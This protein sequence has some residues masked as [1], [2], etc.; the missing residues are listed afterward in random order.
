[1]KLLVLLLTGCSLNFNA[2]DVGK[3]P[4]AAEG[5]IPE[6]TFRVDAA[7]DMW[8]ARLGEAG[9]NVHPFDGSAGTGPVYLLPKE[10]FDTFDNSAGN[11]GLTWSDRI[12][13]LGTASD[14]KDSDFGVGTLAHELG[15]ALGLDHISIDEDPRSIMHP[16]TD[17]LTEPDARDVEMVM[18]ILG[19]RP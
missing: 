15:H 5:S 2:W 19:C 14:M 9:C 1:M 4:V 8:S 11:N 10:E 7:A 12:N 6:W 17:G 13:I 3:R 18:D 16:K